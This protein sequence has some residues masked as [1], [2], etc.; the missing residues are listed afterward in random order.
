MAFDVPDGLYYTESHEWIDP[1][2]D[3]A[4]IGIT[5]FAQDELGDIV[6]VELPATDAELDE[7]DELAVIESIKAVSDVY[8]PVAG[9][10]V[11]GNEAVGDEPELVNDDPYGDGWLV[12]LELDEDF[13]TDSLLS[14]A[15]YRE[16]IE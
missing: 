12:E 6:F 4:R 15:E 10:V 16:Q 13:D 1:D 7:G 2:G 5:D 11:A 8:T 14:A 3:T 9:A